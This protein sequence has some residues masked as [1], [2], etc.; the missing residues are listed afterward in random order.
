MLRCGQCR[1]SCIH[2]EML[3]SCHTDLVQAMNEPSWSSPMPLIV[4]LLLFGF[5]FPICAIDT[6]ICIRPNFCYSLTMESSKLLSVVMHHY[7]LYSLYSFLKI[8]FH[9]HKRN[10]IWKLK[11]YIVYCVVIEP[12]SQQEFARSSFYG[13]ASL[14]PSPRA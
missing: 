2:L 10:S 12:D 4:R 1:D 13:V 11:T 6:M 8:Q 14:V 5:F 3:Q 7:T 9:H